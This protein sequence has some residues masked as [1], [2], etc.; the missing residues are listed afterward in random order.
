MAKTQP[1]KYLQNSGTEFSFAPREDYKRHIDG[2]TLR[3]AKDLLVTFSV[4][5]LVNSIDIINTFDCVGV[6]VDDISSIQRKAS[7]KCW[8]VPFGQRKSKHA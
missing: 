2:N 5:T 7:E 8:V 6:D 1:I 3:L 4:D